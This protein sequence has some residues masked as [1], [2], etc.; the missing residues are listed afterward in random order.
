ME[1]RN[2]LT[3]TLYSCQNPLLKDYF[4]QSKHPW[5]LLTLLPEMMNAFLKNPP[6]G[7]RKI[8]DGIFVGEGVTIDKSATIVSPCIIGDHTEIRPG[9]YLRGNVFIG[10]NCIIGNSTELKNAILLVYVEVPHFNYV[11]DSILGNHS[12]LGA[13]AVCSNFKGDGKDIVIHADKDYETH[14]MKVGAFVGDH[15]NVGC[16]AVLNP[17][18]IIGKNTFVYP[19]VVCRGVYPNDVIVKSSDNIVKRHQ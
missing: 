13:G 12:H 5:E 1:N 8:A 16:N 11:G 6:N 4:D 14:L 18:T 15:G 10:S 7:Y 3:K 19:L 17:G 9:A 2:I